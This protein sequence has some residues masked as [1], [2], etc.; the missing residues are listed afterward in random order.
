QHD[1]N[2]NFILDQEGRPKMR[3]AQVRQRATPEG[4][5]EGIPEGL[6]HMYPERCIEYTWTR[7]EHKDEA[8]KLIAKDRAIDR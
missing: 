8:R 4:R 1:A 6:V 5:A 3:P 2:W 7:R